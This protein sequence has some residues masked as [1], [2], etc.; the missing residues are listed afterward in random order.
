MAERDPTVVILA[1]EAR[2]WAHEGRVVVR[3]TEVAGHAHTC[4]LVV[5][6]DLVEVTEKDLVPD[7]VV[8]W[9]RKGIH[10]LPILVWYER[11]RGPVR[12]ALASDD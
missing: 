5:P 3:G 8:V 10:I 4:G 9:G 12:R 11:G 1:T 2:M 6:S 7:P